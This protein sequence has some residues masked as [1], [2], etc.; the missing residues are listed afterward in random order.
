MRKYW[1]LLLI[2]ALFGIMFIPNV[3]ADNKV[4]IKSIELAEKSENTTINSEAKFNNLEMNF[5]VAFKAKDDYVKYKVVVSNNTNIDY[6]I[7]EDTSFNDSPYMTYKYDVEKDLKANGET[8]VYVTITY[9]KEI[10]SSKL[11]EGKYSESNKAIVQLLDKN[12]N[13]VNPNTSSSIVMILINL[14]LVLFISILLLIKF[15]GNKVIPMILILGLS[16][17]PIT[18]KAIETLKLTINVNVQIEKG[19]KVAYLTS[20]YSLYLTED[21]LKEWDLSDA[22]CDAILNVMDGS[23]TKKYRYCEGQDAIIYKSSKLYSSG[24]KVDLNKIKI[25]DFDLGEYD[26]DTGVYEY[27]SIDSNDDSI[28]NCDSNVKEQLEEI[29]YWYYDKPSLSSHN[30]PFFETDKDIMNFSAIDDDSWI[31]EY[32][33]LK[34]KVPASFTMPD[35]DVLFVPDI[36][37]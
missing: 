18:T 17:M 5:D 1:S 9:S 15:K 12:G 28:L 31:S 34:L 37:T 16:L 3:F 11:A 8:I 2:I 27:C 20:W 35:H 32:G 22:T 30:Y 19:Y 13:T 26:F 10:D 6:K 4:G 23:S 14:F 21:E 33:Y 7:S 36:L 29:N 25:R 24:E